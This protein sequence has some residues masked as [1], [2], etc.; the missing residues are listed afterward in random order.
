MRNIFLTIGLIIV[1]FL[2][3]IPVLSLPVNFDQG[4]VI[5][6]Q[7]L[8]SLP[9][10]YSSADKIQSYLES[11]GSVLANY[12][13]IVGFIDFGANNT[14]N[15]DDLIVGEVFSN[16]SSKFRPR[17]QVQTPFGGKNMRVSDL[18]WKIARENFGN[19][20]YINYNTYR[21]EPGL[22]IDNSSR[23]INPAFLLTM[24]QKESG[25]VYGSN[26]KIDPNSDYG[27][28]L[29]DRALGYYC[30]ENPDKSKSCY[31]ENPKWKYFK[32]FFQQIYKAYRLL[33]VR[34]KTCQTGGSFAWKSG[35]N[36]FQVG[37]VVRIDSNEVTLKNGITCAM[38]IYTPHIYPS[39]YNVWNIMKFLRADQNLIEKRGVDAGYN[40]KTLRK[41]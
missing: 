41:F 37:N 26:S 31:D 36:V 28:F 3:S 22:C 18:I 33:R 21:V 9:L 40:P 35:N 2:T 11:Q 23:P 19:S 39:Q 1:Y 16:V 38:Y 14:A 34:E 25:L 8:Y 29:L 30:F 32:G 17:D 5:G 27:R 24:I 13:P 20:C 12:R 6:E 15:T 4:Q 7:D 10:A